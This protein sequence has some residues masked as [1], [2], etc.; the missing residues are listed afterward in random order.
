MRLSPGAR[1]DDGWLNLCLIPARSRL[2]ILLAFPR[3]LR[4]TFPTQPG[5]IYRQGRSMEIDCEPPA[6]LQ[7]DG[8]AMGGTPALLHI[9]PS[10]LSIAIP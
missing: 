10:A 5:V 6:L 3:L 4:G 9:R 8:T 1:W 7:C 2:G